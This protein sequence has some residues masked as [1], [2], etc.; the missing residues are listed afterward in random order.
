ELNKMD[1]N[2]NEIDKNEENESEE[3]SDSEKET[4]EE[5]LTLD[6]IRNLIKNQKPIQDILD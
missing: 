4:D 2:N 5:N 3:S 1:V 6:L